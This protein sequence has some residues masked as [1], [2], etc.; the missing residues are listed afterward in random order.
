MHELVF[1]PLSFLMQI[2]FLD[3]DTHLNWVIAVEAFSTKK[4]LLGIGKFSRSPLDALRKP[5]LIF[6]GALRSWELLKNSEKVRYGR[7]Q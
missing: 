6:T 7:C 1:Q 4:I 3:G 2:Y 5:P